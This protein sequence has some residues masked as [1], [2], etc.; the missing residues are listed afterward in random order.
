[1]K[2]PRKNGRTCPRP[3]KRWSLNSRD[4]EPDPRFGSPFTRRLWTDLD[5][6]LL[7]YVGSA[8]EFALVKENHWLFFTNKLPAAPL[9]R[10]ISTFVWN[11]KVM[12][13]P[14]AEAAEL[15]A[16][17]RGFH[18]R[19]ETDRSREEDQPMQIPP[20]A[21]R[22]V[23][24]ML[25]DYALLA[26]EYLSGAG[27]SEAD[28]E[29][30]YQDQRQFFEAMDIP[31]LEDNYADYARSRERE[32]AEDLQPNPYT[33]KLFQAYRNDLGFLRYQL[34]LLFMGH[35]L[36]KIIREKVQIP[37]RVWF[38]PLYALYP[39]FHGTPLARLVQILLL[40]RRVRNGLDNH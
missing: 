14:Q 26:D 18:T 3:K 11:R 31:G 40:P 39:K 21:F 12:E 2:Y 1:M 37:K 27:V 23:G 15:A 35:F 20:A 34:L 32:R 16:T 38:T 29:A 28:R 10:L 17:I 13:V 7:V 8:A 36:P 9:D 5:H 30:Y 24:A 4:S 33:E 6:I 22:A 19:V 25:I